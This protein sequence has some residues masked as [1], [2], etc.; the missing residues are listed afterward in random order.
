MKDK[1][2]I[3]DEISFTCPTCNGDGF[4]YGSVN[5][6]LNPFIKHECVRCGGSGMVTVEFKSESENNLD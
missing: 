6:T 5:E 4:V 3:N 2:N 1:T